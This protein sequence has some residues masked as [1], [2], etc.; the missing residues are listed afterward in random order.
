MNKTDQ[1]ILAAVIALFGEERAKMF[2]NLL[3]AT[4]S[5]NSVADT[6]RAALNSKY[7][8]ESARLEDKLLHDLINSPLDA[9]TKRDIMFKCGVGGGIHQDKDGILSEL[10]PITQESVV[11]KKTQ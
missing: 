11:E 4:R 2:A 6:F 8:S 10:D 5:N 7:K 1:A 3:K 9:K